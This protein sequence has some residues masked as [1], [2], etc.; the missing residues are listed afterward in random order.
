MKIKVCAGMICFGLFLMSVS[1]T[2]ASV[3]SHAMVQTAFSEMS[4]MAH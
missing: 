1:Y 2:V 4:M 3:E